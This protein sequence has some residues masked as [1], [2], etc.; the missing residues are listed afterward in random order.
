[1]DM[2][3]QKLQKE[4]GH[5]LRARPPVTCHLSVTAESAQGLRGT[6]SCLTLAGFNFWGMHVAPRIRYALP[7]RP[8]LGWTE[9]S[10]HATGAWHQVHAAMQAEHSMQ[11]HLG[12]L[13]QH[14]NSCYDRT[15]ARPIQAHM[16]PSL[17]PTHAAPL[18]QHPELRVQ[19]LGS[20]HASS[21]RRAVVQI[22]QHPAHTR[23]AAPCGPTLPD[24]P[25]ASGRR[26]PP[27][28]GSP[29]GS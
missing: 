6:G 15:E 13:A 12:H 24:A 22:I 20:G 26:S 29:G 18:D 23:C 17:G 14:C 11:P 19:V 21:G 7:C 3:K 4:G 27:A 28:A 25:P 1:M 16:R 8:N 2:K 9:F 5:A 10:G